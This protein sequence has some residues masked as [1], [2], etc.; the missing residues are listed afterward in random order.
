MIDALKLIDLGHPRFELV[1]P[2]H[3]S[4]QEGD[5]WCALHWSVLGYPA[6]G[7]SLQRAQRRLCEEIAM[8]AAEA[9]DRDL[10]K[11]R[12]HERQCAMIRRYVRDRSASGA[13][14]GRQSSDSS[15]P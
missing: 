14:P 9:Y 12:E 8:L 2:I 10:M 13:S 6:E 7:S 3:V 15:A 4:V 5:R 11:S 1:E